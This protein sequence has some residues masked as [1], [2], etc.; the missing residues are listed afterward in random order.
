MSLS[1][2]AL[3]L[4]QNEV[5]WPDAETKPQEIEVQSTSQSMP[6]SPLY[7]KKS[8]RSG[9]RIITAVTSTSYVTEWCHPLTSEQFPGNTATSQLTVASWSLCPLFPNE[10]NCLCKLHQ[11][12][13]HVCLAG[14][15]RADG[16]MDGWWRDHR[17]ASNELLNVSYAGCL[18]QWFTC[19]KECFSIGLWT[20]RGLRKK[21]W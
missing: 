4:L 20:C 5:M 18:S 3:W 14:N 17:R 21:L 19:P 16:W 13:R 10:C 15:K 11:V 8:Q 12:C 1:L 9:E 2:T 7:F 6:L